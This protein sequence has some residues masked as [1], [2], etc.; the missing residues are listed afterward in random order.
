MIA[1]E[2]VAE[3]TFGCRC[4][5]PKAVQFKALLDANGYT[6]QYSKADMKEQSFGLDIK[7]LT[8]GI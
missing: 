6:P 1:K 5:K 2:S 4:T 3:V 8:W 7:S